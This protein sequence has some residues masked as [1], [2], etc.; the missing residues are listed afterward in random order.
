MKNQPTILIALVTVLWQGSSSA[1]QPSPL[2]FRYNTALQLALSTA[3]DAKQNVIDV[4]EGLKAKEGVLLVDSKA[5]ADLKKAVAALEAVADP[6]TASDFETKYKGDWTLVCST[7]TNADGIDLS[8]IPFLNE[9]PI[10][11]IRNAVNRCLVVKQRIRAMGDSGKIDRVDHVLE[12]QPPDSLKEILDNLPDALTSLNINP[13]QV[14]QGKVTLVH[15]AEVESVTP[16]LRTKLSLESIIRKCPFRA[17][18]SLRSVC[19]LLTFVRLVELFG[20][21]SLGSW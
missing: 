15:K 19:F 7:S 3:T 21:S 12:Y 1:F 5:K 13:L 9:G 16:V 2:R 4:A 11:D 20:C 18:R 10:K 6:P 17:H 8:K 14:S